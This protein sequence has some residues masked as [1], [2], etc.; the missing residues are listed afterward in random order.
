MNTRKKTL[1]IVT[2][3]VWGGAQRYVYDLATHLPRERFDIVVAHGGT[4]ILQE[5]LKESGIRT[6]GI[7]ALGRDVHALKELASLFSLMGLCIRERPDIVHLNSSKAGGIGAVAASAAK[8]FSANFRQRTVFTVHGWAFGEDRLQWQRAAIL[9]FSW[10]STLFHHR[11]I[12]INME[13]YRVAERFTPKRKLALIP[14]GINPIGFF[15][16]ERAR[17]FLESSPGATIPKGAFLIG[18]IA[19][20][21]RTKGLNYLVDAARILRSAS[22]LPFHIA[23]IGDGEE[24]EQLATQAGDLGV[25]ELISFLGFI[26]DAYRYLTGFDIFVLPSVKEGL[27]YV[28][29]EAMAASVPIVATRVGGTPDAV[30]DKK[31]GIL[32]PPKDSHALAGALEALIENRSERHALA[33]AGATMVRERFSLDGM[34]AKTIDCYL[35][36]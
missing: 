33:N 11:I 18:A 10:L 26:P 15:E 25:R 14:N 5:K 29:L 34:I 7:P 36:I 24:R 13:D 19:E 31:N 23:V 8:I 16:R 21:T 22:T 28:L 17:A 9:F 3:S 30:I 6:V 32:V 4:G 35:S 1:F 12:V 20:L 27:P 2:K